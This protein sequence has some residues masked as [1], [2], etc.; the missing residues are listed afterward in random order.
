MKALIIGAGIGGLATSLA[1]RKIGYETEIYEKAPELKPVGAGLTL[2]SNGIRALREVGRAEAAVEAGCPI[3]LTSTRTAKGRTLSQA[4]IAAISRRAG[5]PSIC[6]HRGD[7]QTVLLEGQS[8][9]CGAELAHLAQ[10]SQGV[11]A[12]FADGRTA[13][14]DFLVGADGLHS[15]TRE[16]LHGRLPM[17]YAGYTSWRMVVRPPNFPLEVDH[18]LLILGRGSEVGIMAVGDG[19][20]YSFATRPAPPG[21]QVSSSKEFLLKRFGRYAEPLPTL[22]Q[23]AR[24]EDIIHTDIYDRPPAE[25]WGEGRVTLVGDSIHPTTPNLGQGACQALESA[26]WLAY[27]LKTSQ[28]LEEG[29]RVYERARRARTAMVTN[30]SRTT[31]KLLTVS[32]PLLVWLRDAFF[33]LP[34][35]RR[36]SASSLESLISWTVPAL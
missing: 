9:T 28:H 24:E 32:H 33:A 10:D 12:T 23:S 19:R 3:R 29:L 15:R 18:S 36:L 21:Q 25:R 14:G 31:G 22:I 13:R 16:L 1:L 27:A 7:L 6:I 17:R 35:V 5:A 34:P 2:W 8:V 20:Y 26:I 30:Q 4:D 11:T